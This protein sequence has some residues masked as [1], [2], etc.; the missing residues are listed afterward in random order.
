MM[1][2]LSLLLVDQHL[3]TGSR[4]CAVLEAA[5][6]SA[7][8]ASD[9]ATALRLAAASDYDLALLSLEALEATQA[10]LLDELASLNAKIEFVLLGDNTA[11]EHERLLCAWPDAAGAKGLMILLDQVAQR[12]HAEQTLMHEHLVLHTIMDHLPDGIYA[13]DAQARKT[14]SNRAD[15]E[16]LGQQSEHG[17]LGK[18]DLEIFGPTQGAKGLTVDMQVLQSGESV[19]HREVSIVLPN[20]EQHWILISKVPLVDED[21]HVQG[22]VGISHNI[23]D[24]KQAEDALRES[25]ERYRHLYERSPLPY[26]SLDADG[27]VIEV[28][29]AWLQV[30]G[31]T[32][33][34]VIGHWFGEFLAPET[35]KAFRQNFPRFL[36]QG[37]I[38]VEFNMVHK[39]G[40]WVTMVIDGRIGHDAQGAFVQ[41]HCVLSD[42]TERRKAENTIRQQRETLSTLYQAGQALSQTL[43]KDQVFQRLYDWVYQ[44]MPCDAMV[45]SSFAP[46]DQM[47]RCEFMRVEGSSI[48]HTTLPAIP[49]E[50]EGQGMQS[51]VIRSGEPLVVA[52]TASYLDHTNTVYQIAPDGSLHDRDEKPYDEQTT[53]SKLLVPMIMGGQVTGVI[54]VSS[55]QAG[56][57]TDEHVQLLTSLASQAAAA[58]H[59]ALLYQQAQD[60][61]LERQQIAELLRSREADLAEAQRVG[62][63]G[64]W[65]YDPA[66]E[67]SYWSEEMYHIFGLDPAI[68]EIPYDAHRTMIH[69]DEWEMFDAAVQRAAEEGQGYDLFLRILQPDGALRHI[70]SRCEV[71]TDADGE[72]LRVVGTAQDV[73]ES[74]LAR[75]ALQESEGRFR[76]LME[77]SPMATAIY[78]PDGTMIAM[79][80]AFKDLF[81]LSPEVADAFLQR[82]NVLED[83]WL[84]DHGYRNDVIHAFAGHTV[85]RPDHQADPAAVLAQLGLPAEGAKR[86]WIRSEYYPLIDVEGHVSNVVLIHQ[87]IT[88]ARLA[89]EALRQQRNLLDRIFDILPV[90]IWLADST[91]TLVRSNQAGRSI[92]GDEPLVGQEDYGVFTARRVPSG[93]LLAPEDWA[94][95]HTINEGITVADEELEIDC[96]D[97]STKIILNYTAPVLD[98]SGKVEAAVVVNLDITERKRVEQSLRDREQALTQAQRVAHLGN[99]VWHMQQD[100]LEWSDEMYQIF[101]IDRQSFTGRLSDVMAQ[102]IH[103]D[104]REAVEASNRSTMELGQPYPVEYRV[105]RPDGVIRTVWAEAGELIY[106]QTGQPAI[107]T[108]IVQDITERVEAQRALRQ[109]E[110]QYRTLFENMTEGV[111]YQ[112]AD[113]ALVD[114]NQ[115]GLEIFGLT[116][117]EFLGRTSRHPEWRVVNEAGEPLSPD[118]HPSM[119]TLSTGRPLR[120]CLVGVYHP[121]QHEFVWVNTNG[122][123]LFRPGEDKPYQAFVTMHDITARKQ[124]L[125]A[126]QQSERQLRALAV[127]QQTLLAAIPDIVA[128][129]D[130]ERVY[131]WANPAGLAFF[132]EDMIGKNASDFFVGEQDTYQVVHPLMDGHEDT[133]YLESWQRRQDG[134]ERLLAWWCESLKDEHGQVL[135]ALSTARDITEQRLI[136]TQLLQAQKM[137]SVGRLAGGVAHD[138]NN[139]LQVILGHTEIALAALAPDAALRDSIDEIQKAARRSADLTRQLLA[140]ARQQTVSPKVLDL[141]D[142]IAGMLR[143]LQRLI[144]EEIDL[145]WKPGA[146]LWLVEVDPSQ[147]DQ[148]MANL[149]V[150]ARDA[151]QG[152]GQLL[153]ETGNVTF[154]QEYCELHSECQPGEYVLIGVSD[155]GSGMTPE[156]MAHLFEPFF[157]T[158]AVGQGTGLGLATIYGIVKQNQGFINVYSELGEGTTFKIY[159][160]RKN[161]EV[162]AESIAA[163]QPIPRGAETVLVV[164]D[165]PTILRLAQMSLQRLGYRVLTASTPG[166]ALR[167]S[168]ET[169]S[170]IDLLISDVVMPEMN[171]RVL[172]DRLL[173][174]RP[175]L[176]TLFMSGYTAN[177]VVHRGVVEE[178]IELL[179]KPF[180]IR[181]LAAKVREMLDT[182]EL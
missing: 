85:M 3:A 127:R 39:D 147:I 87:D 105:M 171:G 113:G 67:M 148:V 103:P 29:P 124:A 25:E 53:R 30:L 100:R 139:M 126:L 104:D 49:L 21:G 74:V 138:F 14:L 95:A 68:G 149:S 125:D 15:Y 40:H 119:L 5:G 97:G 107:L 128:E 19:L 16:A 137:E 168:A 57:Y 24:R 22:L 82:Y 106:N 182:S 116:R 94:L 60:E 167:I 70:N 52:D 181:D 56:A 51:R 132:G 129:V 179:Q 131:T 170:K 159:L 28:N 117:E 11:V 75:Q 13:K 50:P 93:E 6:H 92:W 143:M 118:E 27:E 38:Q 157:T 58:Y 66:Q 90:G 61:I 4:L 102:A 48:D 7:T 80:Q 37:Q 162:K 153:I 178:G 77:Q 81:G 115:A 79:N 169:E 155:T 114:I 174:Q 26:Q 177:V 34:E 20:G 32:E 65:F 17:V 140:F 158:K 18:T 133:I 78:A 164:E 42:V 44:I 41:T 160:P 163:K 130:I 150:N 59:N 96:F 2:H 35:V 135:G 110:Q 99:W 36:A 10:S 72:V 64:S 173:Q 73:T 46:E 12:R 63:F 43:D 69:P 145:I 31:Y 152:I 122:L 9:R 88:A 84:S 47:I 141:N 71:E 146:D 8:L 156:V 165:E 123:P 136:E 134:K 154:D 98:E 142:A 161:A 151:I 23:T 55:Y 112:N 62:Q 121:L 1:H 120:D 89:E 54:Q 45:I 176:V 91:G 111:F 86:P 101:G 172:R 166:E 83:V 175:E 33:E 108:G 180:S 76:A 109:S 144:G